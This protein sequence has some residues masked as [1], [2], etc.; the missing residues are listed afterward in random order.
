MPS[1]NYFME[2]T[3]THSINKKIHETNKLR[4]YKKQTLFNLF[5]VANIALRSKETNK[6]KE[7]GRIIGQTN[8]GHSSKNP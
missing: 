8:L 7:Y 5:Y 6:Q 2:K 3:I 4:E 1:P